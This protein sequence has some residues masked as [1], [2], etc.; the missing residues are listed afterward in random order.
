M[1]NEEKAK[2]IVQ[3]VIHD[4]GCIDMVTDQAIYNGAMTMAQ[5][6]ESEAKTTGWHKIFL[7][8]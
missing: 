3:G 4:R 8:P 2:E 1:T 5:W 7:F 6:K